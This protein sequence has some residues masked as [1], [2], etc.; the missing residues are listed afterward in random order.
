MND[1]F[2]AF[3]GFNPPLIE[4]VAGD[5]L[6]DAAGAVR[7]Q[8]LPTRAG[9]KGPPRSSPDSTPLAD[10]AMKHST[11]MDGAVCDAGASK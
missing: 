1:F 4:N 10:R 7:H 3:R 8:S 5:F 11:G 2:L 9:G 6:C